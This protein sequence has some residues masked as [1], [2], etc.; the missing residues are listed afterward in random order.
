MYLYIWY[1][2]QVVFFALLPT[3]HDRTMFAGAMYESL[4]GT[5][6]SLFLN[7]N[8]RILLHSSLLHVFRYGSVA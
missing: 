4:L 8:F 5:K 6:I 1:Q 2:E 7:S 3:P